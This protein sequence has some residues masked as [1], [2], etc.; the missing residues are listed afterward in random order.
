MR[1]AGRKF[2]RDQ[3]SRYDAFGFALVVAAVI[4]AV[5]TAMY[6]LAIAFQGGMGLTP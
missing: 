2:I 1:Q 6:S 4:C 3:E 5:T